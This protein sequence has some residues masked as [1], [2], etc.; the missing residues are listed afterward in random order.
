[1]NET[2]RTFEQDPGEEL[3]YA[4][5]FAGH[6]ARV[7]EPNTEYSSGVKVRPARATGYQYSSGGGVTG[8]QEPRWPT[9]IGNTVQDGSVTWTC[10][11]ITTGSLKR[12]VTGTPTWTADTGL[13]VG[14]PTVSGTKTTSLVSGGTLGQTYLVRVAGTFS[15]GTDLVVPLQVEI[16]RP[17]RVVEA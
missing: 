6:C 3:D 13:T 5:D 1:M 2:L 15:D 11:A 4:V 7:R 8:T 16:K 12:T 9:T 10:E 17:A 14:T